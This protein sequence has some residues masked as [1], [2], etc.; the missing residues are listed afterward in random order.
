MIRLLTKIWIALIP[1][2]LYLF[3]IYV[4]ENIILR[5]LL[6]PK[7]KKKIID[8]EFEVVG[9]KSTDGTSQENSNNK[10]DQNSTDTLGKNSYGNFSLHN[11]RFVFTLYV[12]FIAMIVSLIVSAF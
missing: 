12:S 7:K 1:I 5:K 4:I 3:W 9:E 8:G 11:K 6:Q 10:A 2:L